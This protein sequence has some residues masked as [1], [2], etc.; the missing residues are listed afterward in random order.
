MVPFVRR[1]WRIFSF[2]SL[3]AL[4]TGA[5]ATLFADLL[6]RTGWS[7][8]RS[9]LL[10]TFTVLFFLTALGCFHGVYGFFAR[11]RPAPREV[12]LGGKNDVSIEETRTAIVF[13][14]YNEDVTRVFEGL[15]V[16]YQSLEGTGQLHLFEFLVLS[17]STQPDRWVEEERQWH[18][19]ARELRGR[20]RIFYRRRADNEG[21]KSGNIR[22]FLKAW[23]KRYE[24]FIIFDADSVMG[25]ATL[26][27]LVK[28]MKAN[29][30][31]G[32]IQTVPAMVNSESLFGRIQQFANRFYTPIFVRGLDYWSQ[33]MGNYWGHNAI[34]RTEPFMKCGGL[35]KLP[36]RKPFGG[37]ILSHDFV[38]AALLVR[39]NW[40]VWLAYDCG[41]S[42]EETP[43]GLI[44][45]AQRDRR[46]CQGNLQHTMVLL[47]RGLRGVSRVHLLQGIF[48]YVA[49]P[50]W[51]FFLLTFYWVWVS[52]KFNGLSRIT[53]HS[54]I[55]HFNL[56]GSQHALFIFAICMGVLFLPRVL[57]L[58]DIA[59]DAPRKRA[60]GGM[61]A[62]LASTLGETVFSML[63]APLQMLWHTQF[64]ITAL[65][66]MTVNWDAQQRGADGI[67]WGGAWR[68]L[69]WQTAT[70][71]GAGVAVW[72]LTPAIFWWFTPVF[73]G[74]AL[75]VPL[76]VWT[77]RG[78]W[79]EKARQVGLFLTPEET[80]PPEELARLR[81]RMELMKKAAAP[82]RPEWVESILDPR[83]NAVHIWLL[84]ENA[85]RPGYAAAVARLGQEC[86]D[87][88]VLGQKLLAEG[89]PRL[90]AKEKLLILSDAET[91]SWLHRQVWFGSDPG[92]ADCWREE[93]KSRAG[94]ITA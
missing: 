82:T 14:I 66:G 48:G 26:L 65:M 38:E 88:R 47:S 31:I 33:G 64:V 15:R 9:V 53:V 28:M 36:G 30:Q 13:P 21:K 25:G 34:I 32:L 76:S 11:F 87:P 69:W 42:Y 73:A 71:V 79:G 17:D 81:Q 1:G 85:T 93:L 75:S 24:Y 72:L 61:P 56:T 59:L 19:V 60:F 50:L 29:P 20:G 3:A 27:E 84:Q 80:A 45:N 7:P 12:L 77:S 54:W 55:S 90:D 68:R 57:A 92:M 6:W 70:G 91:M 49:S 22:E 35:P 63:H 46:W 62:I 10:A 58:I 51:L 8:A 16:T 41:G 2:F 43:Q 86:G 37:H 23:G 39:E 44:E 67:S 4:L 18:A 74:L 52:Q 83:L 89:A 78:Q 40:Q 5:V 94:A